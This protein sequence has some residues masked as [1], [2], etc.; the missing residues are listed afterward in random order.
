MGI[1]ISDD[2]HLGTRRTIALEIRAS[3]SD[4]LRQLDALVSSW[5]QIDD[6]LSQLV[7]KYGRSVI[8]QLAE[9]TGAPSR[10][11]TDDMSAACSRSKPPSGANEEGEMATLP[12]ELQGKSYRYKYEAVFDVLMHASPGDSAAEL[13]A[14]VRFIHPRGRFLPYR[15]GEDIRHLL[16][17]DGVYTKLHAQLSDQQK[18]HLEQLLARLKERGEL[19]R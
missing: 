12:A 10:P 14:R 16:R 11:Q 19:G 17:G 15:I 13:A 4:V 2:I 3:L 18:S 8:D 9:S 5:E 6:E 7:S 1:L